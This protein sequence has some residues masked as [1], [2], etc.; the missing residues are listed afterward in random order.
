MLS[1]CRS[2][3]GA[4]RLGR[5]VAPVG[6]E[7]RCH[8]WNPKNV[9][10]LCNKER[11]FSNMGRSRNSRPSSF[12]EHWIVNFA[13]REKA[14][15]LWDFSDSS[16]SAECGMDPNE[17]D[18]IRATII[19]QG[20]ILDSFELNNVIGVGSFGRVV[21]GRHK[22]SNTPCAIKI[23]EKKINPFCYREVEL[24]HRVKG[25]P[26][27]LTVHSAYEDEKN[28]YL[29]S[30]RCTGGELFDYVS[31]MMGDIEPQRALRLGL[32]MLRA[33][34]ACNKAGFCHLDVKPENFMF[35][36][37]G[38]NA[39]LL[40]VDFGSAEP[41]VRHQY[42]ATKH[43]Y[44]PADDDSLA[45]LTGTTMY[46]APEVSVHAKF[47]SRS[48]VWSVG[49]TTYIMVAGELPYQT[50]EDGRTPRY[51]TLN[52]HNIRSI[53]PTQKSFELL[54]S[55]IQLDPS[56]RVSASEAIRELEDILASY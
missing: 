13:N 1:R 50:E 44:D 9:C 55:M 20:N 39:P 32:E 25:C 35:R 6:L 47:S 38:I 27:I 4:I 51:E 21:A 15:A 24:I 31:E 30:D 2:T 26:N 14:K 34:E 23:M 53:F 12:S 18:R 17:V 37:S 19:S 28:M 45:R 48:D 36:D 7:T 5:G 42:A 46:N 29:V 43:E 41:L 56:L 40:L 11:F 49:V 16:T 8:A 54:R 10:M 52:T 3:L 33:L 22:K